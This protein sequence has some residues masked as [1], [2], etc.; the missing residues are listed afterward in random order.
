MCYMA[1]PEG[2]EP[3]NP[4]TKPGALPL[5]DGPSSRGTPVLYHACEG[6]SIARSVACPE[7]YAQ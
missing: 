1:G 7:V 4:R 5:G 2:F 3:P 6:G